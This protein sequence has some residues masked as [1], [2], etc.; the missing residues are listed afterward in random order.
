MTPPTRSGDKPRPQG[1]STSRSLSSDSST[2]APLVPD[3]MTRERARTSQGG[4][5][6]VETDL[7][8]LLWEEAPFPRLPRDAPPELKDL[9]QAI[10]NPRHVYTI[11]KATRRHNFQSLVE[12]CVA[13]THPVASASNC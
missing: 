8:A 12:K 7:I 1:S 2:P 3:D 6:D 10:E 9:V 5:P 4:H 11:H 13:V